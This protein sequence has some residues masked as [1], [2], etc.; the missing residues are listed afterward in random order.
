VAR[1]LEK[2]QSANDFRE[3]GIVRLEFL[4][5]GEIG[6][7]ARQITIDDDWENEETF[8][9]WVKG[10]GDLLWEAIDARIDS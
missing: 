9:A 2:G 3:K 8:K 5:A 1:S 4:D 6:P 10:L 7:L